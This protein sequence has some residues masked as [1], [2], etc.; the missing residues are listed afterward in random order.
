LC[1]S[2]YF[3]EARIDMVRNEG[4]PYSPNRNENIILPIS[5]IYISYKAL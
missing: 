1:I 4:Y 3:E 2:V 5:E